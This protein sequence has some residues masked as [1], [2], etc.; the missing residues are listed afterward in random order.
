MKQTR[1]RKKSFIVRFIVLGVSVFMIATL[2]G[3]LNTYKKDMAELKR[4][5]A[6]R[7][8]MQLEIE[9]LRALLDS[10]SH[11]AII[12]KAA[13][14]RLGFVYTDEEVYFDSSGN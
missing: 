8:T 13:R 12:E 2:S 5:E 14:E 6:E 3:L 1:R 10:D 4:L 11:L 9:Q 7:D